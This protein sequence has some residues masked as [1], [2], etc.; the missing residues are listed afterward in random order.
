MKTIITILIFALA[1]ISFPLKS[2]SQVSEQDKKGLIYLLEEEKLA[3]DLYS[4]MYTKYN[5]RVFG[6]ILQSEKMHQQHVKDLMDRLGISYE[7]AA[8][9]TGEFRDKNLQVMYNNFLTA[10]G[11][12]FTDALRAGAMIE[13]NDI[14]DL[15]DHYAKTDNESIRQLLECLDYASQNHLRA[16]VRN[17]EREDIN[18]TPKVLSKEDFDLIISSKNNKPGNCLQ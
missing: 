9:N 5:H 16:F 12:S 2:Y 1:I 17:L 7:D 4:E 11:Y 8:V 3:Y 13:E 10:G 18:Y 14:K 15:R 6:N